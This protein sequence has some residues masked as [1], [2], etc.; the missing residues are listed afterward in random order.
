MFGRQVNLPVDLMYGTGL[1]EEIAVPCRI[2]EEAERRG[3]C[4]RKG[5]VYGR[6]QATEEHL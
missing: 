1:K 2:C 6:T 3:L 4:S 5:E